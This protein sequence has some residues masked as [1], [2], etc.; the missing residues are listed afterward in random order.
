[1]AAQ[2]AECLV[3]V[4]VCRSSVAVSRLACVPPIA[5]G[6]PT[7]ARLVFTSLPTCVVGIEQ[8]QCRFEGEEAL[9]RHY[10]PINSSF[11]VHHENETV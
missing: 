7:L 1:M 9:W 2:L 6:V 3:C 4:S 11:Y 5:P 10:E 8:V